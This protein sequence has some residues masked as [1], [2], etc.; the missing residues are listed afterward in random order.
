M[1]NGL[2]VEEGPTEQ[3]FSAPRQTYT[4]DLLSAALEG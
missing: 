3:I 1:Q 2:C 4:K